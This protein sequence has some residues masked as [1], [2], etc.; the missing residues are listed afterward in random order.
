MT[1]PFKIGDKV[2][3]VN[4]ELNRDDNNE[5]Q[6]LMDK[7][8]EFPITKICGEHIKFDQVLYESDWF[9]YSRFEPAGPAEPEIWSAEWA[10]E[11]MLCGKMVWNI[12]CTSNVGYLIIDNAIHRYCI[13][14]D[15]RK[16]EQHWTDY[17]KWVRVVLPTGWRIYNPD[18]FA[19]VKV[20]DWVEL[21]DK[22]CYPYGQ[23]ISIDGMITVKLDKT[24]IAKFDFNGDCYDEF[25][26]AYKIVR[27]VPASEVE[28]DFLTKL[29]ICP[30][31]P[32]KVWLHISDTYA[33]KIDM[34][35]IPTE[36]ADK[37][38]AL[39]KAQKQEAEN[40]K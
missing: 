20:G 40:D 27:V 37:V 30:D 19:N 9:H 39:L 31:N 22:E 26:P 28:I 7:R 17:S 14:K 3:F 25:A 24:T 21:S 32:K 1:N 33:L 38:N 13:R 18:K 35:E 16:T 29:T 12:D 10:L 4:N 23:V 36:Q 11:Q 2:R 15:Y 8:I 6:R 34:D 5:I